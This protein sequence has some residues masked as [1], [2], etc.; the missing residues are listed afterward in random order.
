MTDIPSF[1]KE[2]IS[3]PG[4]SGYEVPVRKIIEEKWQPLV[5]E[6]H[7]SALGSLEGLKKGAGK[8]PRH[9]IM[10]AAHMDAIGLMV[11]SVTE[12]FIR[13]TSVGGVDPRVLLG[14]PVFV[15]GREV[16]PGI[17][18]QPPDR[19]IP[20]QAPGTP[21]P[22][23]YLLIDVGLPSSRVSELV[24][25][26]DIISFAQSPIELSGGTLSGH[27]MDD[28]TAVASL[29]HCLDILQKRIHTW[30]VWAVATVQEEVSFGGGFTSSFG[31][32]PD[33]GIAID[34]CHA[35][36]PGTPEPSIPTLGKGVALGVGP[37]VHPYMYKAFKKLAEDLE[38]PFVIEAMAQHSGTDAYPI[39]VAT[40][41][42]PTMVLSIPLRYM[43]TPVETVSIKDIMRVGRITAEFIAHLDDEFLDQI[44]WDD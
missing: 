25:T 37:N 24:R 30:D 29:T 10:I 28:R 21:V 5:D 41:G 16:L 2:M 23:E 40:G 19:L 6:M 44:T 26:G 31:I 8:S 9:S 17:I 34:V 39:Q 43:H 7:V 11:T 14:Q 27:T 42:K 33:L 13:F 38:I 4:L 35:K 18:N 36:G 22:M 15:H 12:G 3:A 20:N 1:L 32:S